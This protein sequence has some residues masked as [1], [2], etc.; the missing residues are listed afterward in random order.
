MDVSAGVTAMAEA[1]GGEQKDEPDEDESA[2]DHGFLDASPSD[3]ES[4]I[5]S[6]GGDHDVHLG[7]PVATA[8][9]LILAGSHYKDITGTSSA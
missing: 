6:D 9:S 3:R 2:D 4:R 7:A 8:T 1:S 5:H